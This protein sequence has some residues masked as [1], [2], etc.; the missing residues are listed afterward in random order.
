M[1]TILR[2]Y[3]TDL[4]DRVLFYDGDSVTSPETLIRYVEMGLDTSGIYPDVLNSE[5]EQYNR[6]SPR[7][8]QIKLKTELSEFS[9]AWKIPTNINVVEYVIDCWEKHLDGKRYSE[10][11]ISK[12]ECRIRDELALFKKNKL[13][14]ILQAIIYIIN[15]LRQNKVVWGVG[16]GSSVSSYVLYL[17]GV[18]DVDSVKYELDFSDFIRD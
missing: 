9:V 6:I 5:I 10:D 18:H 11:E 8:K 3:K 13:F 1:D 15:T 4:E 12:R 2:T 14:P 7:N 16:R 17:I